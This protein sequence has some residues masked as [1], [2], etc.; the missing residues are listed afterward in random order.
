MIEV[1]PGPG[2]LTRSILDA[3]V[4]K[5][6][7]VEKD[8]R[9]IP[10]LEALSESDD[11]GKCAASVRKRVFSAR[12]VLKAKHCVFPGGAFSR[13]QCSADATRQRLPLCCLCGADHLCSAGAM[14]ARAGMRWHGRN[15][16]AAISTEVKSKKI[17]WN[18]KS[19]L[20]FCVSDARAP[21]DYGHSVKSNGQRVRVK[22]CRPTESIGC[23]IPHTP[24]PPPSPP[25]DRLQVKHGDILDFD[26]DEVLCGSQHNGEGQSA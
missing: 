4:H 6:T 23:I 8:T 17:Q 5:L 25:K 21:P 18:H 24:L 2:T 16:R 9:F 15:N 20:L 14:P 10:F 13:V 11:R 3:G 1:G 12:T 19:N 26:Y 7:V 22:P